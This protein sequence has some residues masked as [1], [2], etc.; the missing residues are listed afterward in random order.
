MGVLDLLRRLFSA[1][2]LW[3]WRAVRSSRAI[4]FLV[5]GV[6]CE[7]PAS[8][9][10]VPVTFL[11]SADGEPLGGV[12]FAVGGR[13]AQSTDTRGELRLLLS[14]DDGER[15]SFDVRCP[16]GSTP[17][18][19]HGEVV[20][21]RFRAL[22]PNVAYRGIVTSLDCVSEERSIAVVVR[23]K[24]GLPVLV[25]GAQVTTTDDRGLAH[26][27]YRAA[28]GTSFVVSVD[29]SA[30][31]ELRPPSPSTTLTIAS[32]DEVF[33]FEPVFVEQRPRLIRVRRTVAAPTE[34]APHRPVRLQ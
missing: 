34:Q 29:T 3:A 16:K 26:L 15:V 13:A 11:A 20:L 31:P 25:D 17:S 27:A 12:L 10:T 32:K 1:R 8:R 30:N 5:L 22:D 14:G 2:S 23:T 21:R 7:A 9:V 28:P 24:N 19:D 6:A 33:Q 4:V 18:R